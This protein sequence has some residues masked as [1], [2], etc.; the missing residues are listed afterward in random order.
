PGVPARPGVACSPADA[1]STTQA[2]PRGG[3]G[4]MK[5]LLI[6]L[7][8]TLLALSPSGPAQGQKAGGTV[9]LYVAN[10]TGDD[11]HVID[12]NSLKVRGR[13]KTAAHPHGAAASADG[14]LFFT[15]IESDHTL[16]VLDT[17]T[18]KVLKTV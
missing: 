10:S 1:S 11:I 6:P 12:L 3:P 14:R 15:T 2:N 9:K 7:A 8:L 13:I 4:T 17:A 5:P 18:D 16:L